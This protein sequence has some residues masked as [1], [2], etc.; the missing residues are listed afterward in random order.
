MLK[1]LRIRNLAVA[2][3]VE[4]EFD[5]G[6]NL[7]TG[8]TGA[9]KSILVDSL[10]SLLGGKTGA[11][12]IRTGEKNAVIE[13]LFSIK[14]NKHAAASLLEHGIEAEDDELILRREITN[15][16][17]T[18]AFVQ[19][20]LQ[21]VS[22]LKKLGESLVDIHGQH[23]QRMLLHN[24]SHRETLDAIGVPLSLREKMKGVH[25][26]AVMLS[27]KLDELGDASARA[28]KIDF[29]L[30]QIGEIETAGPSPDE[31]DVLKREQAILSDGDRLASLGRE[32]LELLYDSEHSV[33]VTYG[34]ALKNIEE[35]AQYSDDIKSQIDS[36]QSIPYQVEEAVQAVR[37]F[38]FGIKVNPARLDQVISRLALLDR[39]KS[40]YGPT[41][42]EVDKTLEALKQEH[43]GLERADEYR[44]DIE[45]K[46][47]EARI[48]W[49]KFARRIQRKRRE[50]SARLEK[51]MTKELEELE[52]EKARF[53]VSQE[54]IED[55][56][57]DDPGARHGG[58]RIEFL[59]ST[60]PGEAPGPLGRVASGGE[61][62]RCMLALSNAC[63][64]EEPGRIMV[65]DEIDAGI[66]GG[67]AEVVG[68]KLKKLSKHA[69]ILCVTHLP[70]I[71]AFA[72]RHLRVAK[73]V[74][75]NRT[76][77]AVTVLSEE[78]RI[79]ELSRM[80]GGKEITRLTRRHAEEM[81]K[82]AKTVHK[83][84]A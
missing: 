25:E 50:V 68:R 35:L 11:G 66:G 12:R 14:H 30:F 40:K 81:Y 42:K 13:G 47:A 41:L 28:Q 77:T 59:L 8:E 17:R 72:D 4:V 33:V 79:E 22:F 38:T 75:R 76:E 23:D 32:V 19:G 55:M 53:K 5:L 64:T 62:S 63:K 54:I 2:K 21:P 67:T 80:L 16:G 83:K 24:D 43:S 52:L 37:D 3:E 65:F 6:L 70:Q 84:E 82:L 60:N 46:L 49:Q 18:R 1:F 78:D 71:A 44:G 34:Q 31:Y 29:L 74:S 51:S 69:Q 15:T 56:K 39:L 26:E 36:L 27:K 45:R 57:A 7:L 9:G 58:S 10:A 61:L 20:T 48:E 73:S